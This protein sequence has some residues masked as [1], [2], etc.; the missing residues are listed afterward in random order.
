MVSIVSLICQVLQSNLLNCMLVTQAKKETVLLPYRRQHWC[1]ITLLM[2][3]YSSAKVDWKTVGFFLKISKEIGKACR[4][5]LPCV[6]HEP[7]TPVGRVF[8]LV[9]DLL[10]DC[11]HALEYAKIR[12]VL[13]S[14]AKGFKATF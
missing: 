3:F 4:K 2:S 5:S 7:P 8:S 13:Q 12:T 1:I 10:F 9:P 11:S 6:V 14:T